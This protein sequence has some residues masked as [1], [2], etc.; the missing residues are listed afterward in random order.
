[1]APS[2]R[3]AALSTFPHPVR[4]LLSSLGRRFV[5]GVAR[6]HHRYIESLS[7]AGFGHMLIAAGHPWHQGYRRQYQERQHLA[8]AGAR[9]YPESQHQMT[10][11]TISG[12]TLR[13]ELIHSNGNCMTKATK[14]R[15]L[16][17]N[18]ATGERV[19]ERSR[20]GGTR[21]KIKE[22]GKSLKR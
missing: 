21:E 9:C 17:L 3:D 16:V 13:Y 19:D 22:R 10:R 14:S 7:D 5:L 18:I 8:F 4:L 12:Q 15:L 2:A 1:M 20:Q 6:A 11:H